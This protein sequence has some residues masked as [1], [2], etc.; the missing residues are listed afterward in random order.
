MLHLAIIFYKRFNHG[1]V[2]DFGQGLGK[3]ADSDVQF[4]PHAE[5]YTGGL[6]YSASANAFLPLFEH[7]W[8]P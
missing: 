4:E 7:H 1:Q 8:K 6:G 2:L 3:L 5:A